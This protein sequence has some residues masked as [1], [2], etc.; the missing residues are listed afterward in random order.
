MRSKRY[1]NLSYRLLPWSF[2]SLAK[3]GYPSIRE[4]LTIFLTQIFSEMKL[5]QHKP[6]KV[7]LTRRTSLVLLVQHGVPVPV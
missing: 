1:S 3:I 4:A 5:L 7:E 6:V 2:C